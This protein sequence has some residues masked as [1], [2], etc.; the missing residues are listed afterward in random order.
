MPKT[1]LDFSFN[2]Q[3]ESCIMCWNLKFEKFC[4][5]WYPCIAML[6]DTN[7]PKLGFSKLS[8][9]MI[10]GHWKLYI[11]FVPVGTKLGETLK[12]CRSH[13]QVMSSVMGF[14]WLY[15]R[16]ITSYDAL[17]NWI[18]VLCILNDKLSELNGRNQSQK[19]QN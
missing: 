2:H 1:T 4:G 16:S 11:S 19:R 6:H 12:C 13:L 10:V 7:I 5:I 18:T 17:N 3:F 8:N 15:K 9:K 14:H